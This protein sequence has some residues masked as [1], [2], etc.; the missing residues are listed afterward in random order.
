MCGQ[1][2]GKALTG[3][4]SA[5]TAALLA[6]AAAFGSSGEITRA[7]A[8][9]NWTVGDIVA[10]VSWKGCE[11]ATA[12]SSCAWIPYMTV[13][14][15]NSPS[16]CDSP[17][18]DLPGLGEGV[19]LTFGGG[20]FKGPGTLSYG[21]SMVSLRGVPDQLACLFAIERTRVAG[22]SRSRSLGLDA[23]LLAATPPP[24]VTE[25]EGPVTGE[26]PLAVEEP[27][28]EPPESP[29]IES[30]G[31]WPGADK[32]PA[33]SPSGESDLPAEDDPSEGEEPPIS[34][35]QPRPLVEEELPTFVDEPP[36]P[37]SGE[38]TR[39]LANANWTRGNIAGTFTWDDCARTTG[40]PASYCAWIPYAT[41]GPRALHCASPERDWSSLGEDVAFVSW[42]GENIGA[43]THEFDFPGMWLDGSTDW[44][45]CL[46]VVEVTQTGTYSH[47]LA[48]MPLTAPPMISG[49]KAVAEN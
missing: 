34:P 29:P 49:A 24:P 4:L 47:R 44:L 41:M 11:R 46:G 12:V 6:P 26:E 20:G 2:R 5:L 18:R 3:I 32:P 9:A 39:A 48:G 42:G 38:I 15:G 37:P 36:K 45:L 17:E 13:G 16:E 19:A 23:A 28:E 21:S 31:E 43:G 35:E 33:E 27:K 10:M 25:A 8:N 22:E 1:I 40:A 30:E 7:L 14:P